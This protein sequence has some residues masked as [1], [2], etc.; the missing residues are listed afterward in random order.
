MA[1]L[2]DLTRQQQGERSNLLRGGVDHETVVE[3]DADRDAEH[4]SL[5]GDPVFFQ[6]P[7]LL[8]QRSSAR[9]RH[10]VAEVI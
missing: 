3:P 5:V 10:L 6:G 9:G 2:G 4:L 7:H 1:D 8:F